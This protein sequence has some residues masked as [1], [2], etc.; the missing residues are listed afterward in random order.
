MLG[1]SHI[2]Y[3]VINGNQK[4]CRPAAKLSG[5]WRLAEVFDQ[6]LSHQLPKLPWGDPHTA[7]T[8]HDFG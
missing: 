3:C 8:T 5:Q 1:T 7:A 4:I 6:V 2:Q